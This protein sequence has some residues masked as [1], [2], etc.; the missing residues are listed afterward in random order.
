[1]LIILSNQQSGITG[2]TQLTRERGS[3]EREDGEPEGTNRATSVKTCN[4]CA[5]EGTCVRAR[6]RIYP[7]SSAGTHLSGMFTEVARSVPP[8]EREDGGG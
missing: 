1:M 8:D 3:E 7:P 2:N 5:C 6:F 4:F